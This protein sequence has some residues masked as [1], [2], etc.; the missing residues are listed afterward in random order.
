MRMNKRGQFYL[1]IVFILSLAIFGVTYQVNSISE[2]VI[3]EDFNS[4]SQNYLSES[5]KV[6]NNA[7]KEHTLVADE[8]ELFSTSFLEYAQKRNPNLGLLF[9]YGDKDNISI[10]NYLD[11]AGAVNGEK[12]FGNNQEFVQDVTVR[13]GGKDFIYKVPITSQNFGEDWSGLTVD[14]SPFNLSIA[15]ILHPFNLTSGNPEFKVILRT[16]SGDLNET[17]GSGEWDPSFSPN[18][19]Q[20]TN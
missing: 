7:V 3:W 16:E 2:A 5:T 1:I 6:A 18:I 8:L 9:V 15:G 11:S 10:K 14:N 17:Y 13:I 20:F 19:Q 12:I 4:V